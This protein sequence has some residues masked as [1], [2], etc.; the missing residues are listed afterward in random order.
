MKDGGF[1]QIQIEIVLD[2]DSEGESESRSRDKTSNWRLIGNVSKSNSL[3]HGGSSS[4][5]ISQ[6]FDRH[7]GPSALQQFS[8][9]AEDAQRTLVVSGYALSETLPQT[10]SISGARLVAIIYVQDHSVWYHQEFSLNKS[11]EW[12]FA[13]LEVPLTKQAMKIFVGVECL[14]CGNVHF[15]DIGSYIKEKKNGVE[16]WWKIGQD[17]DGEA[18]G[19]RAGRSVSLSADGSTLAVGAEYNDGNGVNSG[20]VRVYRRDGS[21]WTQ[22]GDDIDGEAAGDYSGFSVSLS[23]DGTTVA[24]GATGNDGNG[25]ESGHVRVYR[26][27]GSSWTQLGDDIDGEA[28]GDR[29][30]YSVSLSAVGTTVAVGAIRNGG[31]GVDSGHVRVY[32]LQGSS[33][34]QLGDDIDGEAA[35]DRAGYSVSLSADGSTVAIG[36]YLND[37]NGVD[38]GHVRVYRLDA[39]SSWTQL[40]DDIDGE[41]AGDQLGFSVSL[42]AFGSTLAVGARLN[43]GGDGGNSGHARV[44]EIQASS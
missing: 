15:D 1:E 11:M 30:G 22:L 41:A 18:A 43:D 12:I 35:G 33:W 17:I 37:G 5:R 6:G 21:S 14:M 10:G 28:A 9:P 27:D 4:I 39:G 44:Y 23:A 8:L 24:I 20:H 19:D 3:K 29:A 26:R 25:V 7:P 16:R 42:S 38:S 40:G 34:T 32:R 36:A 31:N 2:P 13:T